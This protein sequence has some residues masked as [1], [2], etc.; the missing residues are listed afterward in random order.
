MKGRTRS[1]R[2]W[3]RR[4]R[5]SA[6]TDGKRHCARKHNYEVDNRQQHYRLLGDF[7][8]PGENQYNA[9]EIPSDEEIKTE[10]ALRVP[11]PESNLDFHQLA[12]QA[13]QDLPRDAA[14]PESH[15]AAIAWQQARRAVLRDIARIEDYQVDATKTG[16]QES[17]DVT[18]TFWNLR[19]NNMWSVPAVEFVQGEPKQTALIV[20]DEG[21]A[22]MAA[23]VAGL[24]G[25][26]YR[27][28]AVDPF[29][30]G[31]SKIA[32]RDYLY[33]LLV[34]AV[35]GRPLGLQA[36]QVAAVARW[37]TVEHPAGPVTL[38]ATGPRTTTMALI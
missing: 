21:R 14:L 31:E 19:L 28:V 25:A 10:E 9:Q 26:G 38:T 15:E 4:S 11:L 16:Q 7:F 30:L 34:A 3:R 29:Y 20:A 13:C 24:L 17:S 12:L 33:A 5:S 36:G 37:L 1:S 32:Q 8:Y 2:C 22:S 27:V 18:A 6:C 23:Q 35:G